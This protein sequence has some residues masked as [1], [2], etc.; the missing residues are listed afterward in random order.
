MKNTTVHGGPVS[1]R[2]ATKRNKMKTFF[3]II[4]GFVLQIV[5]LCHDTYKLV[6]RV[7]CAVYTWRGT[8]VGSVFEQFFAFM[9]GS[10]LC[11]NV[12]KFSTKKTLLLLP[13]EMEYWCLKIIH[14][15]TQSI[16]ILRRTAATETVTNHRRQ[17]SQFRAYAKHRKPKWIT[18]QKIR[19]NS[20]HNYFAAARIPYKTKWPNPNRIEQRGRKQLSQKKTRSH[21]I[22]TFHCIFLYGFISQNYT[23]CLVFG[24]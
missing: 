10:W 20:T 5:L 18:T 21:K 15:N 16:L 9:I 8:T 13:H 4:I 1:A 2:T 3:I 23:S 17:F 24:L 11:I 22:K 12:V 6:C 19:W 7:L 14:A